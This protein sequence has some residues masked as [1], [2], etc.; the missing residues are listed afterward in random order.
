MIHVFFNSPEKNFFKKLML[1]LNIIK[2]IFSIVKKYRE[3]WSSTKSLALI[4]IILL[5]TSFL[6]TFLAIELLKPIKPELFVGMDIGYGDEQTAIKLIDEVADYVNLIILG[7]LELTNNTQALTRVCDY[8]YQKNLYF[9]VFVSFARH[10]Y[11]PPRGPA[12]DFFVNSTQ[13]WG[14]YFLGVYIFDEVGGKLID[15]AHSIDMTFVDSYSE[16]ATLYTNHLQFF[17]DNVT[18][19]YKPSN[20]SIFTSD[21]ALYWY[22]FLGGY[23]TV[24]CE[25]VGNNNRQIATGLC[26]GAAKTL[27]KT[28][29]VIITWP[30]NDLASFV[31]NPDRIY[32][33]MLYA[34]QNDAKYII[35]FNSPGFTVVDNVSIPNPTPTEFGT[36]TIEHLDKMQQFWALIQNQPQPDVYSTNIAY[37]L[38]SDFGFGFR[39]SK[40]KIW[41]KW[42]DEFLSQQILDDIDIL[43]K[44]QTLSF[45][46]VYETKTE[47]IPINHPYTTLIFWNGTKITK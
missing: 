14:D 46:I 7:S 32:D 22:D 25:Y 16:A 9:I 18:D 20:F 29:G 44:N 2:K 37:V 11:V 10:G 45:D 30:H 6:L 31:E 23:D 35:V 5:S 17:L 15:D 41:G 38:P 33:D 12:S 19:Y 3:N 39:N 42:I 24:F 27:N 43:L 28:W 47:N 4:F 36:L 1:K 40:D 8:L 26:R 21:Y 34:Y 13:K